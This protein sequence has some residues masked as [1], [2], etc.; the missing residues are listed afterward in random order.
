[1]IEARNIRK[2][3]ARGPGWWLRVPA[4]TVALDDVSL[5]LAAGASLGRPWHRNDVSFLLSYLPLSC[6]Q[7]RPKL[8]LN[9]F[10]KWSTVGV[11]RDSALRIVL[12]K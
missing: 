6:L 1:M 7:P 9:Y 3:F 5:T 11:G 12:K 4:P 2:V 10:V 8:R